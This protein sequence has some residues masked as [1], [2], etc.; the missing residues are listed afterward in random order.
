MKLSYRA[1]ITI[2]AIFIVITPVV[3]LQV[4]SV[5][6]QNSVAKSVEDE[7]LNIASDN[8]EQIARDIYSMC[9]A[10][11]EMLNIKNSA[12]IKIMNSI[13]HNE[14]GISFSNE[15]VSWSARNQ[16]SSSVL[17]VT[18]PKMLIGGR[19]LGQNNNMN[20]S[21]PIVDKVKDITGATVTI[22][23]R[24]DDNG[25]MIRVATNVPTSDNQRAIGTYIPAYDSNNAQNPVI[26]KILNG[27]NFKGISYVVNDWYVTFYEPLK[28]N[29]G[30]IIGMLYVGERLNSVTTLRNSIMNMKVGKTGY[31]YIIGAIPPHK[32]KYIISYKGERDGEDISNEASPD[33]VKIAQQMVSE[34]IKLEGNA[35]HLYKYLWKNH[36]E[37]DYRRKIAAIAYFKPW[38][39][40][41]GAGTYED[42]YEDTKVKVNDITSSIQY[43]LFVVV[44]ITLII[45]LVIA[46]IIARR[47][48]KPLNYIAEVAN[49][50]SSGSLGDAKAM[51]KEYKVKNSLDRRRRNVKDESIRLVFS[52]EQM[53]GKLEDLIRK[54]QSSGITVTQ[55]VTQITASARQLE[56]TISEQASLSSEV[57]ASS[58]A[59]ADT[60]QKI[61]DK[62][63][64]INQMA[65]DTNHI[66]MGGLQKLENMKFSLDN[67][68][69]SSTGIYEKLDIIKNRTKNI[70]NI[71]TAIT[72][73]ANQTNLLSLNASI[74]AERAGEAGSGFA[75]VAREIRRLADQTSIAALDIE[76]LIEEMQN[77]VNEG[78][79]FIISYTDENKNSV[80]KVSTIILEIKALI[81]RIGELP[82]EIGDLK[83]GMDSQSESATQISESMNQLTNAT[84][85]TRD[86][87]IGF[88]EAS[89]SLKSAI[90][91]LSG[92]L[93]KFHLQEGV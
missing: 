87:I 78:T 59:I 39:W 23:Q 65:L 10:A 85:Q 15:L 48:A 47:M 68:V 33:G 77:A 64:D 92:E 93:Q 9:E 82:I 44:A 3:V 7:V 53:I 30:K 28:D 66:A 55:T 1:K 29:N 13:I 75:I 84:Q 61:A 31:T 2:L 38:G 69:N 67:M 37:K 8:V 5:I 86:S 89:R 46:T 43:R 81:Q 62:T 49:K 26:S 36:G 16:F 11:D 70:N 83:V 71:V 41:I 73:V 20:I 90:E 58:M 60:S 34:G 72:K 17:N 54:V 51:I 42:D 56:G 6:L 21:S 25:S 74:E 91:N 18:L 57:N 32:G 22:F 45:V 52:F 4:L 19:W 80:Q 14:G 24:M 12:S 79:E 27:Q 76:K 63:D 35:I 88:N 40:L 50:I